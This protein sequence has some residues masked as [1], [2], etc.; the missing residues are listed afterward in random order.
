MVDR[1][2]ERR[3]AFLGVWKT[4]KLSDRLVSDISKHASRFQGSPTRL[5]LTK[6]GFKLYVKNG[7]GQVGATNIIPV[8]NVL[9]LSVN[10]YKTTCLMCTTNDETK[11][12]NVLVWRCISE[13]D[14]FE[15]IK[16]FTFLRRSLGGEGEGYNVSLR[17]SR[18]NNWSLG[19][20]DG[21]KVTSGSRKT[22]EESENPYATVKAVQGDRVVKYVYEKTR[23]FADKAVQTDFDEDAR[24]LSLSLGSNDLRDELT[25]LSE[26]VYAI[27]TML[28][29]VAGVSE[30]SYFKAEVKN[31]QNTGEVLVNTVEPGVSRGTFVS[32][33]N[34]YISISDS[35]ELHQNGDVVD[36]GNV[37]EYDIRSYGI[38]TERGEDFQNRDTGMRIDSDI[39]PTSG[40]H[41]NYLRASSSSTENDGRNRLGSE[42]SANSDAVFL[43]YRNPWAYDDRNRA[44]KPIT[45]ITPPPEKGSGTNEKRYTKRRNDKHTYRSSVV[46]GPAQADLRSTIPRNIEDVYGSKKRYNKRESRISRQMRAEEIFLNEDR[47]RKR[48]SSAHDTNRK[49]LDD[50][51][52]RISSHLR[53]ASLEDIHLGSYQ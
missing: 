15:I 2:L 3:V 33:R 51:M 16:A 40:P 37:N 31:K 25:N 43:Q 9:E 5:H 36:F 10:K 46:R 48:S 6:L 53:R 30:P 27:K 34:A 22:S 18:G 19:R 13:R 29:K 49:R 32:S 50:D 23:T 8:Q 20:R 52:M 11:G 28:E 26:E 12:L 44:G 39:V 21:T 7:H 42:N 41:A 38:Q 4:G 14:C 35:T 24:S 1:I 45:F 47:A 17:K